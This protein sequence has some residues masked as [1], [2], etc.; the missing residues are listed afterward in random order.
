[1]PK[2]KAIL[3]KFLLRSESFYLCYNTKQ[4]QQYGYWKRQRGLAN[5]KSLEQALYI[6]KGRTPKIMPKARH[7]VDSGSFLFNQVMKNVP[8]LAPKHQAFVC[9]AVREESIASMVGVPHDRDECEREKLEHDAAADDD[10]AVTQT[11][12]GAELNRPCTTLLQAQI[13]KRKLYKQ[14]SGTEVP[15]FPHDN[16]MDLLKELCWEAGK[17]R[18]VLYG[19]PAS[20]A[21]L[22]GCLE[23]GCSV[24]A[25]CCNDHHRTHIMK[26]ILER[27]VE[28]M[29][30]GT[31]VVFKDDDLQARSVELCLSKPNNAASANPTS[32]YKD[33][34]DER[35]PGKD[36]KKK[37]AGKEDEK[38]NKPKSSKKKR[39]SDDDD[40]DDDD[41]DS[42]ELPPKKLKKKD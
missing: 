6:F 14:L 9:R 35:V 5:S 21:G 31:T 32:I 11:Q 27:A 8:V 12:P 2:L 29:V 26:F 34:D 38:K 4:M 39:D 7:Y 15:W 36:D 13:K 18:W 41:E 24:V 16:D 10:D 23:M 33:S 25:L 20:G 3:R 19:T 28:A 17:P 42:E 30:A 40:D 1:M 37:K 22:H